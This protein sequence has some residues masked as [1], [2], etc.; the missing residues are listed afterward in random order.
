M[1]PLLETEGLRLRLVSRRRN[2]F[3]RLANMVVATLLCG[4]REAPV[5]IDVYSTLN[6]Y[7]ACVVGILCQGRRI[8][9]ICVLHGGGLP[10][11]L[12]QS[13]RVSRRLFGGALRLVAPSGYLQDAFERAGYAVRQIPNFI[14]IGRYPYLHRD[15]GASKGAGR[16]PRLLWVR[17]FSQ[18]YNPVMAIEVLHRVRAAYPDAVLCMIGPDKGDGSRAACEA[19]ARELGLSEA[20]RLTGGLP[21]DEWIA[22]SADYD[23]FINTTHFDN[24]PVS[25]VEAMALGF[26]IVSTDVGGLP[27]LIEQ[28]RSGFLIA[29]GDAA[30]MSE[31]LL[32][33]WETPD[34]ARS[35]SREARARAE[36]YD[37]ENVKQLWL[38]ALEDH[39]G[40]D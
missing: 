23:L 40:A 26:P 17:A 12:T 8:P 7:Y 21:K 28:G 1:A 25:V 10:G 24:T 39:R 13:A 5:V 18:I 34:L 14:R 31:A 33:I 35:L 27:W 22:L 6:F 9:Y 20:L 3:V 30:A 19:R 16:G 36:R 15:G 37:W 11:R 29:D 32:R 2:R 4:R 38:D